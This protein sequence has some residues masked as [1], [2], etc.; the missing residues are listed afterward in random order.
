[1]RLR[2]NC[3]EPIEFLTQAEVLRFVVNRVTPWSAYRTLWAKLCRW[4]G[5]TCWKRNPWMR[6]M[7]LLWLFH[8]SPISPF[9]IGLL[10]ISYKNTG[11]FW[12]MTEF[13]IPFYPINPRWSLE[14]LLPS[15]IVYPLMFWT[16]HW[17]D[18][19]YQCRKCQVCSINGCRSR[20]MKSFVSNRTLV[21][22]VLC[23]T[24][25]V[26]VCY[27]AHV[28]CNMWAGLSAPPGST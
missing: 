17:R 1:M 25:G 16:L 13:W 22:F 20:R 7:I 24:T 23:S 9:S 28:S 26:V 8:V 2:H 11:I 27:S 5:W 12:A 3:T 14:M 15:G 19:V 4:T 10:Q 18:L 21:K 6:G